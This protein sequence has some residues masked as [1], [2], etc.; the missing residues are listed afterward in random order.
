ME[1]EYKLPAMFMVYVNGEVLTR[2]WINSHQN[3]AEVIKKRID[4]HNKYYH[5]TVSMDDVKIVI[6][7]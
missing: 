6:E 7:K 2:I 1:K 3:P 4:N 5:T